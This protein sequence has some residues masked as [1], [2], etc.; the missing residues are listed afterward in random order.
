MKPLCIYHGPGCADGF[1]AA[2]VVH[3]YFQGEVELMAAAYSDPAPEL[4]QVRGRAVIIVDFS[5]PSDTLQQMAEAASFI[6]VLDHH[7]TARDE[8]RGLS[9]VSTFGWAKVVNK[10]HAAAAGRES[11]FDIPNLLVQ[12][13]MTRSGAKM[14]WDF[15]HPLNAAPRLV[16]YVED[17]DLWNHRLRGTR[18]INAFIASTPQTIGDWQTLEAQLER[19]YDLYLTVGRHLR[20]QTDQ[21]VKAIVNQTRRFM[22]I[23][24]YDVPVSNCNGQ[25]ASEVAGALAETNV[26]GIGASYFD[27]GES[28]RQFSLRRR[29]DSEVDVSAIAKSY[30]GGG[31]VAAAGFTAPLGWEGEPA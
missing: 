11:Y 29:G 15:F 17:R 24:G 27:H 9:T 25:F 8:L 23:G 4:R 5:Y 2:M 21:H 12:F 31:H 3:D 19:D 10:L 28:F 18:E 14:A 26:H 7:R 22:R 6:L 20:R 30:G 1:T 13:D 16:N